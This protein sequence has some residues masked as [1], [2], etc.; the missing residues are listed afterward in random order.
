M[1]NIQQVMLKEIIK[2]FFF[3]YNFSVFI[4]IIAGLDKLLKFKMFLNQMITLHIDISFL[5]INIYIIFGRAIIQAF[6]DFF[7]KNINISS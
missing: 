3:S 6:I 4:V 1:A 7:Q 2:L 5:V